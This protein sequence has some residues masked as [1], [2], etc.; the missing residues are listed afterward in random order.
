M[1][2]SMF[3]R[4]QNP[5]S[6]ATAYKGSGKKV[7]SDES[8]TLEVKDGA[9]LQ[10]TSSGNLW[11]FGA[12]IT[13]NDGNS[14]QDAKDA[15]TLY[16]ESRVMSVRVEYH[17]TYVNAITNSGNDVTYASPL[18]LAPYH[19]NSTNLTGDISAFQH[20]GVKYK[21][22]NQRLTAT[23]KA[24]EIADMNWY[25]TSSPSAGV[26]GIKI[27][28][29]GATV[30]A[31]SVVTHGYLYTTWVI[32]FR[33]RVRVNTALLTDASGNG[34]QSMPLKKTVTDEKEKKTSTPSSVPLSSAGL[35]VT[36]N[37]F[38]YINLKDMSVVSTE[39]EKLSGNG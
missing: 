9:L 20:A 22:L 21:S 7:H 18:F 26:F 10:T 37:N 3:D 39:K 38:L 23:V 6:N 33:R 35:K 36:P 2:S 15:A 25:P 27:F 24:D 5:K 11:A 13:A 19:Q 8:L 14:I 16:Q 1:L 4:K 17:P 31:T 28:S 12:L 34:A 29:S 30:G 32:Q